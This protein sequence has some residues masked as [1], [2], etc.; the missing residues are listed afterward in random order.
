MRNFL[1]VLIAPALLMVLP[2]SE[3]A[4]SQGTSASATSVQT[5]PEAPRPQPERLNLEQRFKLEARVTFGISAILTPALTAAFVMADPPKN[6]P[7]EW[8]D[9]AGAFGRN[10][11]A[12]LARHTAGGMTRFAVAAVDGEDPRY[13]ASA[14]KRFVP[15]VFHAVVFTVSDRSNGGHRT[16]AV[17]NFAGAAAAGFVSMPYEPAGYN[18]TTHGTQRA[19]LV[20]GSFGAHNVVTEFAPD[21]YRIMHKM[22][23]PDWM[24]KAAI[25]EDAVRP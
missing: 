17:S 3:A 12:G 6:Y 19:A 25:S 15:R 24:A 4:W 20:F 13:Y 22:H 2:I 11:G 23:F 7:R 16:L 21:I 1:K 14:S 10:Y 5:L 9:G 8:R 18:D